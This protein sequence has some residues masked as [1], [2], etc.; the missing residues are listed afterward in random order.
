MTER[1][2]AIVGARITEFRKKMAQVNKI[3]RGI[4]NKIVVEVEARVDKFQRKMDKLANTIRTFSTIAQN[5]IGGG[6][7]MV[8]PASVPIIVALAGALASLGPMIGVIGGSTFALAT[9]FGFA[10]SAALAFGAAAI[11]TIT[12][13][14][15]ETAK[16]TSEQK[17]AKKE[18]TKF[19]DTWKGITKDLEKPVLKA[20]GKAMEIAN[21]TL[22]MARPL[23]DSAAKA[24][25]N[26]LISLDASLDSPPIKAFFDYMN[27]QAGPMLETIGKASGNFIKGFMSMMT[28]FGPLAEDTAKGFLNMSK[29]FSDWAA[30]LSKSKKFQSFVD[31]INENMPKI[32]AIFRDALAGLTYFFAAFGPLS[33]DMMTGLQDMMGRFKEWAKTLGENKQF[34][35]FIGYIRDNAP[36]VI[37]LIGNLTDFL[38]NLGIGLAP[39]GSAILDIVN[40]VLAW[41]NSMMES[42]PVIGK[43]ISVLVVLAGGLIAMTPLILAFSTLFKGALTSIWVATSMMRAKF[44]LGMSMMVKS[45]ITTTIKMIATTATFIAKWALIGAQSLINGAKVAAAWV[46]ATGKAMVTA[47]ASMV[48]TTATFIAKWALIGT[49]A[50]INAVKV[51]AAWTLSTGAAMATALAGMI[52]T[53]ATFIAKWALIG[54]KSLLHAGKVAAAWFIALGPVGW[55]IGTIIGLVILIIAN[56]EKV[57]S[58]T[59]KIWT[60]ISDW[61]VTTA[62]AIA[63]SVSEKFTEIVQAISEKMSE[64]KETVVN[65]GNGILDFFSGIDLYASGQAIIQSAIDGLVSMK[66]NI[67]GKVEDI[68]GAVRDFWPFSPAKTGPLSDIHKM[69][70]GGPIGKSINKA[71][72]SVARSMSSLANIAR[73]SFQPE[74]Q[75]AYDTRLTNSDLGQVRHRLSTELEKIELPEQNDGQV[76][77]IQIGGYEA[78]GV[79]RYITREQDNERFGDERARGE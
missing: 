57:K 47:L 19:Q 77:I 7:L 5:A 11:P 14:F 26:L 45:M 56:W 34:Q 69:D 67:L 36:K 55:V 51:A 53:S 40:N 25:N 72:S 37:A 16:L 38:I 27:K 1:L 59:I 24:V 63:K 10:G 46:L 75:F 35:E 49:K 54:A 17:A 22:K 31:Y 44:V 29:G 43:I 65:I 2:T 71:K 18:F 66:Q 79:I 23:F 42:H 73:D 39:I 9:A 58:V 12:K 8:S 21:K 13:L 50:T 4:P 78:K 48:V 70:F 28:A 33:S 20:F 68:V 74:T 32:R 61:V 30:G 62:K 6:M 41:T 52:A 15:D 3:A 64:A 76:A 60:A